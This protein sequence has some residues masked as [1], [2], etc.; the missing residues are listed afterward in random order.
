MPWAKLE[1]MQ[2]RQPWP[3]G[4]LATDTEHPGHGREDSVRGV[5]VAAQLRWEHG[6]H[7]LGQI[8]A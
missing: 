4:L 2:C 3:G 5:I 1:R 6:K 8:L 7:L